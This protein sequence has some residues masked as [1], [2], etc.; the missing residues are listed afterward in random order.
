MFVMM[1][2]TVVVICLMDMLA[3]WLTGCRAFELLCG[4]E[5]VIKTR[6]LKRNS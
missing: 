4:N 1:L 6:V 3:S 2:C 5:A